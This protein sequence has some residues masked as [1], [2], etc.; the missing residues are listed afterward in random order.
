M[1][2]VEAIGDE[3][4]TNFKTADPTDCAPPTINDVLKANNMFLN[5][6]LNQYAKL[7]QVKAV[8]KPD[9][10]QI[11]PTRT[12]AIFDLMRQ[13]T[14]KTC[15]AEF[16]TPAF[17]EKAVDLF[18]VL[19]KGRNYRYVEDLTETDSGWIRDI[20]HECNKD[21]QSLNLF[22]GDMEEGCEEFQKV[23]II[24]YLHA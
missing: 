22:G 15:S 5:R 18:I 3:S 9:H 6:Q 11:K 13:I 19:H 16:V 8:P 21:V 24:I 1:K 20:L 7:R 23:A 4:R 14:M 10:S 2:C 12:F 17:I